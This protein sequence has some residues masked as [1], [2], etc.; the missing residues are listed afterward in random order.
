MSKR[1]AK[2]LW[3][4][5][6]GL[7]LM[8]LAQETQQASNN[9]LSKAG[10]YAP[11]T[12]GMIAQ[13]APSSPPE[14]SLYAVGAW[15]LYTPALEDGPGKEL[16]SGYCNTC[17]STTYITMQPAMPAAYWETNV[18]RMINTFGATIPPDDAK[19]IIA[20][21]QSH[22][23][24]ETRKQAAPPAPQAAP[25]TQ[26]VTGST[27]SPV[28][29]S[30]AGCHQ[31]SG[32]GIPGVFPP[33]AGHVPDI[34]KAPG[35]RE[36]IVQLLLNGMAGEIQVNGQKYN[37]AMP[38]FS[39]LNDQDIAAVLNHISTQWGN[40][41]LLPQGHQPFSTDEIKTARGQKLTPQQVLEA[42]NKL[43]LK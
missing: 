6:L 42:R 30:C 10:E 5:L 39:Q 33:L 20:Y 1:H 35:G 21:L 37:G 27:G 8:A 40:D 31:A 43:G 29:Q 28:Y 19:Q 36:W 2:Y 11:G 7:G 18:N 9:G 4:I 25:Q 3:T 15:P 12:L 26:A 34:L 13:P 38:D 17:H 16:V 41:K 22:Y 24:I 14:G 32:A 23:T